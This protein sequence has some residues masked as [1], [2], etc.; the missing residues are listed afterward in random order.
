MGFLLEEDGTSTLLQEDGTSHILLEGASLYNQSFSASLSHSGSMSRTTS[1]NMSSSLSFTGNLNRLI[2]RALT[3]ALSFTGGFASLHQHFASFTAQLGFNSTVLGLSSKFESGTNGNTVSTS[4]PGTATSWGTVQLTNGGTIVYDNTHSYDSIAALLQT[5]ANPA[6]VAANLQ[7]G[8]SKVGTITEHYGR[9]Y[10]YFPSNPNYTPRFI[11]ALSTGTFEG[12]VGINSAGKLQL[13]DAAGVTQAQSTNAIALNQWIRI[14][15]HMVHSTTAGFIEAKLFNSPDSTTPT[16]VV[17]TS[18]N[19][20]TG[21][22]INTLRYGFPSSA[23]N[24][25]NSAWLDNVVGAVTS[26]PGPVYVDSFFK[27]TLA[28]VTASLSFTGSLVRQ[29]RRN[30]NAVLSFTASQFFKLTKLPFP[31]SLS[32]TGSLSKKN[33]RA[34]SGSLS[35]T[36]SLSRIAGHKLTATLS[37]TGSL[38]KRISRA[39]TATFQP[40][41]NLNRSNR[42]SLSG[43]LSFTGSLRRGTARLLTAATSFTG[44]IGYF[45][46]RPIRTTVTG[47]SEA[48]E[49]TS[50]KT[51][52]IVSTSDI[53]EEVKSGKHDTDVAAGN[54][55]ADISSSDTDTEVTSSST[56]TEL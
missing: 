43:S 4:D 23:N 24:I 56:N 35:F 40:T 52:T 2:K 48:E 6:G 41:G 1:H 22:S 16:E 8:S 20:N 32:F 53:I 37:F 17:S 15:Y 36:G 38:R 21:A 7:W 5:N 18:S 27:K 33:K 39:L 46:K 44:A 11:S 50:G 9:I 34:L 42:R 49:V 10:V 55:Q 47:A 26:Y 19:L 54:T 13:I 31:G 30:F 51:G 3:G 29:P 12:A 45:V 28:P 14:E 25:N